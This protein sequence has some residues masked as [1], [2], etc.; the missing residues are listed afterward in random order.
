MRAVVTV[1]L[2]AALAGCTASAEQSA[3]QAAADARNQARLEQRLARYTPGTPQSCINPIRAN[4]TVYGNT[5]LYND[6]AT[7]YRTETSG[8]CFGLKRDDII[9]TR[10]IGSQLCRGDLV[11]TVD[12]TSGFPSG[13]CAFGE[14]TPYK[15]IRR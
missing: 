4:S 13:A 11:R 10:S 15:R 12:R 1:A 2:L 9:V 8:G 3:R 7:L 14:F 5:I 6:G